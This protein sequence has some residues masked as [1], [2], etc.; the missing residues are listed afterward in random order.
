MVTKQIDAKKFLRMSS[1][2][3]CEF[4]T[5]MIKNCPGCSEWIIG[6][7]GENDTDPEGEYYE[8]NESFQNY[9]AD[10]D[11]F[12]AFHKSLEHLGVYIEWTTGCNFCVWEI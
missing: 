6:W 9:H 3:R 8:N 10:T 11:R 4:L 12:D 1:K 7:N 2:M 5:L